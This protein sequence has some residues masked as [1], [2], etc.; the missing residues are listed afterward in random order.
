MVKSMDMVFCFPPILYIMENGKR[1]NT[2]VR[3]CCSKSNKNKYL[4]ANGKK[5][6]NAMEFYMIR[7][8]TK[9]ML[10]DSTAI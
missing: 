10:V 9:F 5:E 8:I 2:T 3:E 7:K 1:T 4:W 6:H